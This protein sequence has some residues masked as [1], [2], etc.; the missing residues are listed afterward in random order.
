MTAP[1]PTVCLTCQGDGVIGHTTKSWCPDCRCF[2][3]QPSVAVGALCQKHED[4]TDIEYDTR[5]R[6]GADR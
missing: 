4:E 6:R 2:C 1:A 5:H 3:G